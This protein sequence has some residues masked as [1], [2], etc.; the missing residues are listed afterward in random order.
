MWRANGLVRWG[1][2]RGIGVASGM[3]VGVSGL[4]GG[5]GRTYV[6]I[7]GEGERVSFY[8]FDGWFFIVGPGDGGCEMG[9]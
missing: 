8:G 5:R 1:E 3:G 7:L 4:H 2:C 9:G 6:Y